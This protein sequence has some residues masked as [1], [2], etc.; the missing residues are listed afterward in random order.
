MSDG[1]TR[2]LTINAESQTLEI[3]GWKTESTDNEGFTEIRVAEFKLPKNFGKDQRVVL[4]LGKVEIMAQV[5]LNGKTYDTLWMPP[6]ELDVS[7]VLKKGS[8]ELAVRLT[9]TTEGK[10][11]MGKT[12]QLKTRSLITVD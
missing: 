2:S 1:S 4:D 7:D 9:S 12:V 5:S 3:T 8:N 10:P 6:Y 11:K